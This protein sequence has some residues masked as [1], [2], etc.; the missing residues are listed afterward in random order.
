MCITQIRHILQEVVLKMEGDAHEKLQIDGVIVEG[1]VEAG[2]LHIEL[3]CQPGDTA[4]LLFQLVV[5]ALP[6]AHLAKHLL[7]CLVLF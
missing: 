5:D 6:D 3:P 4:A 2:A 7:Q 1:V